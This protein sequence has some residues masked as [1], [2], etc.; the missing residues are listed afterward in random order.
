MKYCWEKAQNDT[1]KQASL[2]YCAEFLA[3][4]YYDGLQNKTKAGYR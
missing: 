1:N 4:L 2:T 3:F